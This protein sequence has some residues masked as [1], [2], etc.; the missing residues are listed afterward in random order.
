MPFPIYYLVKLWGNALRWQPGETSLPVCLSKET[1]AQT[2]VVAHLMFTAQS[3]SSHLT[4]DDGF[5]LGE[6]FFTLWTAGFETGPG[7]ISIG[8]TGGT[9]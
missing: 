9:D 7:F 6:L 4:E 2:G 8:V 1:E 5:S 3:K